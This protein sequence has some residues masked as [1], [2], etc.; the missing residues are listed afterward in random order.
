MGQRTDLVGTSE[1][2]LENPSENCE[3]RK[4]DGNKIKDPPL[5]GRWE[6]VVPGKNKGPIVNGLEIQSSMFREGIEEFIFPWWIMR[7]YLG[8]EQEQ[9]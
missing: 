6:T 9:S 8:E 3:G 5:V 2:S 4:R 7:E 1:D